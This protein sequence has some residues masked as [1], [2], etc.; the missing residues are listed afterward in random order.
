MLALVLVGGAGC[1]RESGLL[2][3]GGGGGERGQSHSGVIDSSDGGGIDDAGALNANSGDA[4]ATDGVAPPGTSGGSCKVAVSTTNG[5]ACP[6]LPSNGLICD[7][8][9]IA[10]VWCSAPDCSGAAGCCSYT[11]QSNE[12]CFSICG[13]CASVPRDVACVTQ[14]TCV[15][16]SDCNG[17][18]P[19]ICQNCPLTPDGRGSQG[20]AHWTCAR[21]QCEVA[22]CE[23]GLT[24]PG[25]HG[26]PSYYLPPV[27]RSCDTAADCTL[28]DH[29]QSCCA[30][31]KLAVRVGQEARFTELES[32]CTAIRED[33]LCGCVA[34]QFAEDGTSPGVGQSFEAACNAGTCEAV[35]GGR[36]Q[37][38]T[39]S[40]DPGQVCCMS[41]GP[42]T[43]C[44]YTCAAS[45]PVTLD[46]A[47]AQVLVGCTP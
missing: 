35:V 28:V 8:T 1:G 10:S 11:V 41:P 38:G 9:D 13:S 44:L 7:L 12:T 23:A 16:D 39:G 5:G 47:G 21:G 27:D 34:A 14:G 26:C 3:P 18:L 31:L 37:C 42:A 19:H 15:A 24:C 17:S 29:T 32:Q 33:L 36:L 22:Y 43:H 6:V 46:D 30:A 45:C 25:G 40:C 2:V 20:C 4:A